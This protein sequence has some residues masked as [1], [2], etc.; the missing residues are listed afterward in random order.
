M[1]TFGQLTETTLL[2]LQG[3]TTVQDQATYLTQSATDSG[4]TLTVADTSALSRGM[5][6]ID[7][8]L[9]W[10]DTVD[11]VSLTLTA[12]PYG[13]GYR[14]TTAAAH[15]SGSR[16][17]SSPMFP[18]TVV[19]QA[20][21][22]AVSGVFPDLFAVGSTSFTF[23]A[24]RLSYSL[25]AGATDVLSVSWSPPGPTQ[26]WLPIRRWSL[27]RN[28]NTTAFATGASLSIYDGIVP[29]RTINVVY[30]KEPTQMSADADVFTTV[31]GL[32]ASAED[33]I[34]LGAAYRLVPFF[35]S[36]HLSGMSSE[37]DFSANMR[38]VGGSSQLGR[39]LMQLY[40]MRLAE[41][42]QNL[43]RIYPTRSHYIR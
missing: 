5:V 4:L 14:G 27:D 17:V 12:P 3:F 29:G 24:A 7:D 19:K 13:R 8:E 41:E 33:L 15:A 32:P 2:Y 25:P 34:R 39:Y 6:E 23:Q 38:P 42:Q 28:A 30:S 10:V 21:N 40:Q 1:S 9:I 36:A 18:R 11:S 43:Q 20:I 26:E 31:T 37:A 22:E 35:D 16:V